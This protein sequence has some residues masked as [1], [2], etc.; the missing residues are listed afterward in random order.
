VEIDLDVS[1]EEARD[2]NVNTLA[3]VRSVRRD[4]ADV[5][6]KLPE[7]FQLEWT[8]TQSVFIENQQTIGNR[9]CDRRPVARDMVS[10]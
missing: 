3:L 6:A 7:Y 5:H 8:G 10:Q 1:P 9:A 2:S 4:D